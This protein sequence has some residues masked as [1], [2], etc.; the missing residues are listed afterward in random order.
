[1][2]WQ[3]RSTIGPPPACSAS[4]N[5]ALCGPGMRLARARPR[6]VADR[7]GLRPTRDRL[8][9]LRRVGE[10]LEVAAED[11]GASRPCRGSASPRLA[12]RGRAASCRA[13]PCRA[14]AQRSTASSCRWFGQADDHRVRLGMARSPRSR[15]VE[16]WGTPSVAG[17]RVGALLG[18]R[19]DDVDAV[20]VRAGRAACACRRGRSGPSRAS[21]PCGRSRVSCAPSLTGMG[22]AGSVAPV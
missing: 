20:A 10:V 9:R 19:V 8:Q 15:S 17:E 11:A 13:P 18:A 6:D 2:Q 3:P 5:H 12:V 7:A 16:A 4:Q 1:M 22:D 14:R 21:S